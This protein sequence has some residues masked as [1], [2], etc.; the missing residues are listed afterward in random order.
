MKVAAYY[1]H[2]NGFEFMN[3][4]CP[5]LWDEVMRVIQEVDADKVKTKVS[6]EQ[7]TMDKLLFSPKDLNVEFKRLLEAEGWYESR[8]SYW[9]TADPELARASLQLPTDDQKDYI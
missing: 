1:S 3:Y 6:K 5:D 2:M 8:V 7:R 4:H 9:V